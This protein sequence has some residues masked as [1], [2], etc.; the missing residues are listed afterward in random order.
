MW[1]A[2]VRPRRNQGRTMQLLHETCG[3]TCVAFLGAA[4]YSTTELTVP[5]EARK[6]GQV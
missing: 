3:A 6:R 1:L 5:R 4:D 2:T